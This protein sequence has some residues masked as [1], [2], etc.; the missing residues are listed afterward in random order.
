M[1]ISQRHFN[2]TACQKPPTMN[3]MSLTPST[4]FLPVLGVLLEGPKSVVFEHG[5]KL[6]KMHL[7]AF[8]NVAAAGSWGT[9][10]G[11][12]RRKLDR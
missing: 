12:A 11:H 3:Q 1:S 10:R 7:F 6:L 4:L 5:K 2:S 9:L 8:R